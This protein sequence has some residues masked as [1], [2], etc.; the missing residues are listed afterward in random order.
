MWSAKQFIN[1]LEL[2]HFHYQE[3]VYLNINSS[4]SRGILE[5]I[6]KFGKNTFLNYKIMN[7]WK[8][9]KIE[10]VENILFIFRV[11]ALQN[12]SATLWLHFLNKKL[13]ICPLIFHIKTKQQVCWTIR[14]ICS[15]AVGFTKTIRFC[16][17]Q[18]NSQHEARHKAVFHQGPGRV[19]RVR[20][21]LLFLKPNLVSSKGVSTVNF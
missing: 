14:L 16:K 5:I 4:P 11:K 19:P 21:A 7:L 1:F 8:N 3:L 17:R 15:R 12:F 13:F 18:C 20:V 6:W 10:N 9:V 2:K